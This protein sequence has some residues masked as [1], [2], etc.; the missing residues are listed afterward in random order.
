MAYADPKNET[1]ES[2]IDEEIVFS[3]VDA[4]CNKEAFGVKFKDIKGLVYKDEMHDTTIYVNK[5]KN[6]PLIDVNGK[7]V[8][9]EINSF[10]GGCMRDG[11]CTPLPDI[12][13]PD[14]PDGPIGN[15]VA[16]KQPNIYLSVDG[17]KENVNLTVRG[18]LHIVKLKVDGTEAIVENGK[19]NKEIKF[20]QKGDEEIFNVRFLDDGSMSAFGASTYDM[21]MI[22]ATPKDT[23]KP[24]CERNDG[25]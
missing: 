3:P 14:G 11:G 22:C 2:F 8:E 18:E 5:R 15:L 9:E 6:K 4:F 24:P 10:M 25:Y 16:Q 7:F 1:K 19:A 12:L 17:G 20:T 13:N 21:C 23:C